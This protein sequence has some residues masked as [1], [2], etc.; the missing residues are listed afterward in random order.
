MLKKAQ[1]KKNTVFHRAYKVARTQRIPK[2]ARDFLPVR[3]SDRIWPFLFLEENTKML[4]HIRSHRTKAGTMY[5]SPY[6]HSEGNFLIV[7]CI[8]VQ[9]C[10][11]LGQCGVQRR[12]QKEPVASHFN[13]VNSNE[14]YH[15]L[16]V[17]LWGF[18]W[19][20]WLMG[21][22]FPLLLGPFC[23]LTRWNKTFKLKR[24]TRPFGS[25]YA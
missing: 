10:C 5:A 24:N 25:D 18:L 22:G 20:S 21:L 17:K 6:R 23:Y 9:Y 7:F 3:Q 12:I 13:A 16:S 11:T 15:V 14:L 1:K 2:I 8:F 19:V 4:K